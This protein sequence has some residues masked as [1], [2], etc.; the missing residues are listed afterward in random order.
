M[1]LHHISSPNTIIRK[2]LHHISSTSQVFRKNLEP[3][4]PK[5]QKKDYGP[6]GHHWEHHKEVVIGDGENGERR[7]RTVQV[8]EKIG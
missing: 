2:N 7:G 4:N 1:F 6:Y 3:P 8:G 5:N